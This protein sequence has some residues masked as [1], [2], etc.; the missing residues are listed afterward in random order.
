MTLFGSDI[1]SNGEQVVSLTSVR[2]L[3]EWA[4]RAGLDPTNLHLTSRYP[5]LDLPP[6][7]RNCELPRCVLVSK[8]ALADILKEEGLITQS[9]VF[10]NEICL[11][12][13]A[14]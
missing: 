14:K 13:G 3:Q 11:S 1:V 12:N 7:L 9:R 10:G 2:K 4:Q 8:A 6:R 5:H